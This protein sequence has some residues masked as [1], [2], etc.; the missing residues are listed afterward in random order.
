VPLVNGT[1]HGTA[2]LMGAPAGPPP[3]TAP[4]GKGSAA[5]RLAPALAAGGDGKAASQHRCIAV[6]LMASTSPAPLQAAK[7]LRWHRMQAYPPFGGRFLALAAQVGLHRFWGF[8][9][10]Q[11]AGVRAPHS[12]DPPGG[13]FTRPNSQSCCGAAAGW[14]AFLRTLTGSSCLSAS[15]WPALQRRLVGQTFCQDQLGCLLGGRFAHRWARRLQLSGQACSPS[16]VR[17]LPGACHWMFERRPTA[18]D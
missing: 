17:A 15:S 7:L 10:S 11:A 18:P 2:R 3:P 4:H 1:G 9:H 8:D 6:L 12:T 16:V 13:G 5:R 14:R